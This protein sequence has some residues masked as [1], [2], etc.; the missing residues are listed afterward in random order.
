VDGQERPSHPDGGELRVTV[1]PGA[2]TIEARWQQPRGIGLLYSF[3]RLSMSAP[4]VNLTQQLELPPERWLLF[5]RGSGWGPAVLFWSYLVF[6]IVVAVLLARVPGSPLSSAQWVLLGLGLSVLPALA[7]LV[8]ASFVFALTLRAQ[9]PPQ[10]PW[11]FDGLQLLLAAWGLASLGLL[12]V[13]VHQGLLF[14]P[15]MQVSG[16]GSTDTVLRWYADRVAGETPP[17]GVVSVSLWVYRLAMLVWALWLAAGLVRAAGPAWRA[18]S[19]GGL[20]RRLPGPPAVP[21][22][23]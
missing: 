11:A 12:Y 4:A 2:H 17:A 21:S 15:D 19:E 5:T 7:A 9:R 8:V 22:K 16:G 10:S 6:L 20:W 14:R 1:P 23:T 18:F 13:A 3:P